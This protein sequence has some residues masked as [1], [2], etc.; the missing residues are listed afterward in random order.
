MIVP[1]GLSTN[2]TQLAKTRGTKPT[3]PI[4]Q[5]GVKPTA[6]PATKVFSPYR[7]SKFDCCISK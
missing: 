6:T 1:S 7:S 4:K 5:V 3:V 2:A